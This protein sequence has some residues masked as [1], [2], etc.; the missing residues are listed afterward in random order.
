MPKE[1]L[2]GDALSEFFTEN[3][4][5]RYTVFFMT[6][7]SV[8][9][10]QRFIRMGQDI[11]DMTEDDNEKEKSNHSA[12]VFNQFGEWWVTEATLCGVVNTPINA[13]NSGFVK[14]DNEF[15]V[16]GSVDRPNYNKNFLL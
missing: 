2:K 10:I 4:K 8:G 7:A 14:H 15:V 13:G 3:S 11:V 5:S 6:V 16:C 9:I 1:I 12:V